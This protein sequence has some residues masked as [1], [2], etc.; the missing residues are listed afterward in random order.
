MGR[1]RR[2]NEDARYIRDVPEKD[3]LVINTLWGLGPIWRRCPACKKIKTLSSYY[4]YVKNG[5]VSK[6]IVKSQCCSCWDIYNG[7]APHKYH[8]RLEEVNT[9]NN[10]EN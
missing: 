8:K 9:L 4:R 1:K 10:G 2:D 7:L 3:E 6:K 5:D